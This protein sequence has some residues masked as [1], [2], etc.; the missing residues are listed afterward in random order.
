M[1]FDSPTFGF[2]IE[3]LPIVVIVKMGVLGGVKN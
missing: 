2:I 1:G 3:F